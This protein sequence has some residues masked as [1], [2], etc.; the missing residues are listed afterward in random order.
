MTDVIIVADLQKMSCSEC[1]VMTAHSIVLAGSN[2]QEHQL[3]GKCQ[4]C[5]EERD[6]FVCR[7]ERIATK[8][9]EIWDKKMMTTGFPILKDGLIR[10]VSIS[11]KKRD[12]DELTLEIKLR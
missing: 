4:V 3:H 8:I 12:T 5:G 7:P 1:M 2:P 10:I 6:L 9:M 11:T